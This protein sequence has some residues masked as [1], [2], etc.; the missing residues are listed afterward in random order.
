M[1]DSCGAPPRP[2]CGDG[3]R[4]VQGTLQRDRYRFINEA[5]SRSLDC[6]Y[7]SNLTDY[8]W[9]SHT[10]VHPGPGCPSHPPLSPRP[11]PG[12]T[13]LPGCGLYLWRLQGRPSRVCW[14]DCWEGGGWFPPEA[15]EEAAGRE[16]VDS[17]ASRRRLACA[18]TVAAGRARCS[19]GEGRC[20]D[21]FNVHCTK[22]LY[23]EV[24]LAQAGF[25]GFRHG[26]GANEDARSSHS[27]VPE[28]WYV[29]HF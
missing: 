29:S 14:D 11:S 27:C 8:Y 23:A 16:V 1:F 19:S 13:L 28:R 4:T 26:F 6:R 3:T 5:N 12:P 24:R 2:E 9:F 15:R 10:I 17:C 20:A 21:P 25:G 7:P 22:S 18:G